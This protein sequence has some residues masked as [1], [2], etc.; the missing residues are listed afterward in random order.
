MGKGEGSVSS[1]HLL[2][3]IDLRVQLLLLLLGV[4]GRRVHQ[5]AVLTVMYPRLVD[6]VGRREEVGEG[7]R[8][9]RRRVRRR[10]RTMVRRRVGRWVGRRVRRRMRRVRREEGRHSTAVGSAVVVT[11]SGERR[12]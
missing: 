7:R 12:R 8:W 3:R 4:V 5:E 1:M 9:V 2:D 10:V 6:L 11:G